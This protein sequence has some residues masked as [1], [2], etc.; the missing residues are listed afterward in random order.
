VL[1][2]LLVYLH[3]LWARDKEL[4]LKWRL[5]KHH[6]KM[7]DIHEKYKECNFKNSAVRDEFDYLH[8][9]VMNR[10]YRRKEEEQ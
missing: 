9:E 4:S 2:E 8:S 1:K 3:I 5:L 6:S 10:F 7:V